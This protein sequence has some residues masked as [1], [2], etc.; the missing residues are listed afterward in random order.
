M[1][2]SRTVLVTGATLGIG[3]GI[4]T[5]F[6][7]NGYNVVL[8]ARNAELGVKAEQELKALGNDNVLFVSGDVTKLDSMKAVVAAALEKFGRLDVLCANAGVFPSA[9]LDV[10]TEGEWDEIFN[11]NAKGMLFS[12]QAVL[13]ALKQSEAGRIVITSSIT[14]PVTGYPGWAH[15]GATKSAQLGFMRTAAVELARDGITVN[16]VLPGN[17]YTEGLQDLGEDYLNTMKASIPMKRLGDVEDIGNAALFFA[18]EN[19]GY[20]TGQSL[21]VDGGQILPETLEAVDA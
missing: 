16:A 4:A 17:I 10:M 9:K 7:R 12:I 18:Q 3:N 6:V 13:D 15:Y 20:I 2:N 19:A 8:T 11:V 14:G 21:I 5:V 1:S